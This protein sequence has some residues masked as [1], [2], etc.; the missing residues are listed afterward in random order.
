MSKQEVINEI[1]RRY[2][3]TLQRLN[4]ALDELEKKPK[5]VEKIVEVESSLNV[6]MP[7]DIAAL[8]EKIEQRLADEQHQE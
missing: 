3:K 7:A 5:E 1:W 8:E 6:E 4:H 2:A